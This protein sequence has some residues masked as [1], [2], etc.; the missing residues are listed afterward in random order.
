MSTTATTATAAA[1]TAAITRSS[2]PGQPSR[3]TNRLSRRARNVALTAHILSAAGWF[4]VAVL[5]A[6]AAFTAGSTHDSA[7]AHA[8]YHAIG[9]S[10][11]VSVPMGLIALAT[12][13]LLGVG[14]KW[15]LLRHWWVVAKLGINL[16]V[17]ATDLIVV[18][19]VA[20]SA[21]ASGAGSRPLYDGPIAHCVVLGIA[22][23]LSVF[24]PGGRT[25]FARR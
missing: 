4:G 12:G 25:P 7:F 1:R 17:V 14:T 8:L 21:L 23:V 11:W 3:A 2:S 10:I 15:G 5:V 16:A 20:E 13:V 22:T 6:A 19:A 24:K 9:D 18:R